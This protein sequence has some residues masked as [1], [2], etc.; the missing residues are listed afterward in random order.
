MMKEVALS[1]IYGAPVE[2]KGAI[3]LLGIERALVSED[4]VGVIMEIKDAHLNTNGTVHG[5]ILY[6]LCDQAIGTYMAYKRVDARGMDGQIHYYRPA[7]R[8]DILQGM[9]YVRQAGKRVTVF[10]VEL[11]NQDGKL[12]ADGM[13]TAMHM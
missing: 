7:N 6:A 5:G 2:G 3:G 10:F 4:V 8:G 9:A 11:K 1:E 12:L 13:F